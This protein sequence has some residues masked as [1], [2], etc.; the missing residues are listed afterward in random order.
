MARLTIFVS[1]I[2]VL[3]SLNTTRQDDDCPRG[4]IH[5]VRSSRT[6]LRC[7]KGVQCVRIR[8]PITHV[9]CGSTFTRLIVDP[10]HDITTSGC[11]IRMINDEKDEKEERE[12]KWY[13]VVH[14]DTHD[15]HHNEHLP[16]TANCEES[17]LE[18]LISAVVGVVLTIISVMIVR[19]LRRRRNRQRLGR[20]RTFLRTP[21]GMA[22]ERPPGYHQWGSMSNVGHL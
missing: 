12:V 1:I 19:G 10:G 18:K 16:T 20:R 7:G 22:S 8:K 14:E 9:T 5:C 3:I 11:Q 13:P 17:I 15:K 4:S 2:F 6:V 21:Q